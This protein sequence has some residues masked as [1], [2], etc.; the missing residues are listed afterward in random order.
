MA[1]IRIIFE[2][3]F[4]QIFKF[5]NNHDHYWVILIFGRTKNTSNIVTRK[6]SPVRDPPLY[7]VVTLSLMK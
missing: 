5:S 7:M 4:I 2:G 6:K 1:Q 3:N